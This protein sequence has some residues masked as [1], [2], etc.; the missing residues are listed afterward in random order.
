MGERFKKQKQRP[1][2]F[3]FLEEKEIADSLRAVRKVDRMKA[4]C[5]LGFPWDFYISLSQP[6]TRLW[7]HGSGLI[8]K[9]VWGNTKTLS[10]V[11]P[12]GIAYSKPFSFHCE[13]LEKLKPTECLPLIPLYSHPNP[14]PATRPLQ[15]SFSEEDSARVWNNVSRMMVTVSLFVSGWLVTWEKQTNGANMPRLLAWF[16]DNHTAL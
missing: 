2:Q 12:R 8:M 7:N 10:F 16:V 3:S 15:S 14:A 11:L 13:F 1:W 4:S 5:L 6:R 9:S